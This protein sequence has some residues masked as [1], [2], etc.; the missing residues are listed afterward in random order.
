MM[1]RELSRRVIVGI[2]GNCCLYQHLSTLNPFD[3]VLPT[4]I[5]GRMLCGLLRSPFIWY[6]P[7]GEDSSILT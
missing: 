3:V 7:L 6:D 1:T 4:T 5:L 2:S